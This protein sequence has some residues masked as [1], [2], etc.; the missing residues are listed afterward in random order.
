MVSAAGVEFSGPDAMRVSIRWM[1]T[2]ASSGKDGG[3]ACAISAS[4]AARMLVVHPIKGIRQSIEIEWL[5]LLRH[6]RV[7]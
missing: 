7:D 6:P 5:S 3:Q 4:L 1:P 2:R